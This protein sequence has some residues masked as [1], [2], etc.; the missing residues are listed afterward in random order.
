MKVA[1]PIRAAKATV[2]RLVRN[3]VIR[4]LINHHQFYIPPVFRQYTLQHHFRL[5]QAL[6]CDRCLVK[7]APCLPYVSPVQN[8]PEYLRNAEINI[9]GLNSVP[10]LLQRSV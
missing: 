7:L 6:I 4:C 3:G 5:N 9:G 8:Y 10:P 2:T 1:R